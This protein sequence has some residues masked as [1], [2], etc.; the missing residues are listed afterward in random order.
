MTD[1]ELIISLA[2]KLKLTK[3]PAGKLGRDGRHYIVHPNA[4]SLGSGPFG[5]SVNVEFRFDES[6]NLINHAVWS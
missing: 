3:I 4:V 5:P 1:K 2:E 6:G